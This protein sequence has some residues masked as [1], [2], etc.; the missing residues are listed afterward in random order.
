MKKDFIYVI[1]RSA[2][3]FYNDILLLPARIICFMFMLIASVVA[4]I[5]IKTTGDITKT[6]SRCA[7][8]CSKL[9]VFTDG[10]KIGGPFISVEEAYTI[11]MTVILSKL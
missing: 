7:M 4:R 3:R 5:V 9:Y 2:V 6:L 8:L 11:M 10:L 1:I